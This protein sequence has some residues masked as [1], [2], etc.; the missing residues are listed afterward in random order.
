MIRAIGAVSSERRSTRPRAGLEPHP[1][2][3]L[4]FLFFA[5]PKLGGALRGRWCLLGHGKH[6]FS[7]RPPPPPPPVLDPIDPRRPSETLG[8]LEAFGGLP[9]HSQSFF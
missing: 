8:G 4:D 2:A 5:L 9:S 6:P 3:R 7:A 1:A